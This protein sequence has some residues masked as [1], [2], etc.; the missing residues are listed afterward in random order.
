MRYFTLQLGWTQ[1]SNLL[2]KF[3]RN[4]EF[5]LDEE[6]GD[7][8]LLNG[9][10]V[11]RLKCRKPFTA[12]EQK[13]A[14]ES[15]EEYTKLLFDRHEFDSKNERSTVRL[16]QDRIFHTCHLLDEGAIMQLEEYL[17]NI[18]LGD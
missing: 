9:G 10:A 3:P 17:K 5:R 4:F 11:T 1:N 18:R 13:K 12:E 16:E 6:S 14:N 15:A 2:T 7:L 8:K